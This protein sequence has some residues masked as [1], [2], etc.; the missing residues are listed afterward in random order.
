MSVKR[1]SDISATFAKLLN[2]RD[3]RELL[4]LYLDDAILP[5]DGATIARG[6]KEIEKMVAPFFNGPLKLVANCGACYETGDIALVR[7]NWKLMAPDSSVA[8]AGASAEV[9]RRGSDSRWRFVVDDA[10]YASRSV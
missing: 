6:K 3:R 10:T 1:P 9:L 7:T 4:D 8:M 2:N 5:I